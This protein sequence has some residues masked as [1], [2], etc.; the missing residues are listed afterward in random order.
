MSIEALALR[1]ANH[2]VQPVS[3]SLAIFLG[4]QIIPCCRELLPLNVKL[5]F[6]FALAIV[7]P[8]STSELS[9]SYAIALLLHCTLVALPVAFACEGLGATGRLTDIARGAQFAEQHLP[10]MSQASILELFAK[11]LA[12]FWLFYVDFEILLAAWLTPV[13]TFPD[14][15]QAHLLELV[16]FFAQSFYA[17]LYF[18]APLLTVAFLVDTSGMLLSKVLPRL[19]VSFELL[20]LKLVAVLLCAALRCFAEPSALQDLRA[21]SYTQ[22][23]MVSEEQN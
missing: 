22:I 17:G 19:P 12:L 1:L 14:T 3:L 23:G 5:S 9:F 15:S 20:P 10:G 16:S 4:L 8:L 11:V 21:L 13:Q 18:A 7:V 6:A 2:L